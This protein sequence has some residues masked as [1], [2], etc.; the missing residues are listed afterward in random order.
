M[1]KI[2]QLFLLFLL[3][4][5]ILGCVFYVQLMGQLKENFENNNV[6]NSQNPLNIS[7]DCPNQLIDNGE[8]ILL[9]NTKKPL[10]DK[11]PMHFVNMEHY[12]A[13]INAQRQD[14]PD[15]KCPVLYLRKV[16]DAQG[17]LEYRVQTGPNDI[18]QG[19]PFGSLLDTGETSKY[20]EQKPKITFNHDEIAPFDYSS[21]DVGVWTDKDQVHYSTEK[22]THISNNAD[23]PNWGGADFS[24]NE[25]KKVVHINPD[26]YDPNKI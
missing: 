9:Y 16:F 3:I 5:F 12:L 26:R 8:E 4:V 22:T 17:N 19:I 1:N 15:F 14:E 24:M 23:D 10:G 20:N 2:K 25:A 18:H 13:F 6:G 21:Q 11:N 7:E